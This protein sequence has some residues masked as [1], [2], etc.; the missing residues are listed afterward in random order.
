MWCI[1]LCPTTPQN[2]NLTSRGATFCNLHPRGL[3]MV[4]LAIENRV[5]RSK[6]IANADITQLVISTWPICKEG[7]LKE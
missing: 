6:S 1:S 2:D 7:S 3:K 4:F 5:R